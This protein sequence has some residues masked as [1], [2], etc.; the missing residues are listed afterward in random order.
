MSEPGAVKDERAA[1]RAKVRVHEGKREQH[2]EPEDQN[3]GHDSRK[4]LPCYQHLTP[5]R[6]QKVIMKALLHHLATKQPGK[7]SQAA[8]EDSESKVK[9]LEDA[10]KDSGVFTQ[11]AIA[12]HGTV[13]SVERDHEG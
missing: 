9:E 4:K 8:E 7:Q 6:S 13:Q 12:P 2:R 5:Q 10:G 11:T 3:R 1:R